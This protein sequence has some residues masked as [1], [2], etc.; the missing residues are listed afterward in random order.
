M[1]SLQRRSYQ[2]KR[3]DRI[4][5]AI[6]ELVPVATSMLDVGSSE[7]RLARRVADA[8]GAGSVLGVDVLVQPDPVITVQPYDGRHLPFDDETFDLITVVD[9]LHHADDPHA[10]VSE[11]LRVLSPDGSLVVKDHLRGGRWSAAV[12]RAM[13]LMGNYSIAVPS[14]G[15]YLDLAGWVDLF[16]SC[17]GALDAVRWPVHIH[18]RP[19]RAVARSEYQIVMRVR[20]RG[21]TARASGG[22]TA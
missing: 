9:V 4:V 1:G 21:V 16:T 14:P 6:A 17:G 10:V 11:S 18:D 12:L 19:W 20:R 8:V 15:R 5:G 7:G 3:D 2:P 13:D 22:G